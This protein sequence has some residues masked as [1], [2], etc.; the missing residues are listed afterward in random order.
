[1]RARFQPPLRLLWPLHHPRQS[2]ILSHDYYDRP[3]IGRH[4]CGRPRF[5]HRPL[6]GKWVVRYHTARRARALD[7]LLCGQWPLNILGENKADAE[8]E[9]E[10]KKSLFY[11]SS[12]S[13]RALV[14]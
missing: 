12:A 8:T 1:M 13:V 7:E 6:V 11:A 10:A 2:T 9:L 4:F 3:P 14:H 5:I